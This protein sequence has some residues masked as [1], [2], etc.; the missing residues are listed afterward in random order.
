MIAYFCHPDDNDML[1][2]N[3]QRAYH[4]LPGWYFYFVLGTLLPPQRELN[5]LRVWVACFVADT[6]AMERMRVWEACLVADTHAVESLRVW[7]ACLVADTHAVERMRVWEACCWYPRC[8]KNEGMRSL[9]CC[10]YPRYGITRELGQSWAFCILGLYR[11][12]ELWD[13]KFATNKA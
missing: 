12:N 3:R 11:K 5:S 10:W 9:F 1:L 4:C 6:H 7:E 8:G 13:T 2:S